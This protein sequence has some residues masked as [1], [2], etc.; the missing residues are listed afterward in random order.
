VDVDVSSNNN[1]SSSSNNTELIIRVV[2]Q[3]LLERVKDP[4]ASARQEQGSLPV[5]I[6]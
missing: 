1:N 3:V 4:V 5:D 6:G 2:Q